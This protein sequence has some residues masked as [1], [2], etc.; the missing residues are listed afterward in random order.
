MT[1]TDTRDAAPLSLDVLDAALKALDPKGAFEG[2]SYSLTPHNTLPTEWWVFMPY[3]KWSTYP[4]APSAGPLQGAISEA[5]VEAKS[6]LRERCFIDVLHLSDQNNGTGEFFRP[7]VASI[8]DFI[9]HGPPGSPPVIRYVVGEDG[10]KKPEDSEFMRTLYDA[11]GFSGAHVYYGNFAPSLALGARGDA[12]SPKGLGEA[13][14]RLVDGALSAAHLPA[15]HRP[16]AERLLAALPDGTELAQLLKELAQVLRPTSWNHAKIFALNGSQL[17]IGGANYW[18][19]Y[20]R[21]PEEPERQ[22]YLFDL[23]V[24]IGGDAAGDAHEFANYLWKYLSH[25][26]GT[27]T[28]SSSA[29][30]LTSEISNFQSSN[31][32]PQLT[33]F[34]TSAG[35]TP[36]LT[37]SRIGNWPSPIGYPVQVVDACRDIVVN[38]IA[39]FAETSGDESLIAYACE[40]L[41]DENLRDALGELGV[42]PTAWASRFTHNYAISRAQ[43]HVRLSQ[44]KLVM[45]DLAA[46]KQPGFEA[47]LRAIN[48]LLGTSWNGYI[49][50]FDTL[51]ALGHAL[52]T[53][54]QNSSTPGTVQIVCSTRSTETGYEDPVSAAEFRQKLV[55]VMTGMYQMGYIEPSA[56]I[57]DIVATRLEYRRVTPASSSNHANHSKLVLVDDAICYVG[58]DNL[59]PNYNEE[60]GIWIDDQ[61]AIRRF[62]DEWWNGLWNFAEAID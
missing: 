54:S 57:P 59:Y 47:F 15:T 45:D 46:A 24:R 5:I 9:E 40:A 19:E 18:A 22:V 38:V 12:S 32:A 21:R 28:N 37:V 31:E 51:S 44:Q 61:Q 29:G 42:N 34:P 11:P 25:I 20:S 1:S 23:S 4:A 48:E 7:I 10:P 56:S 62:V 50:P 2:I 43:S 58:S 53:F 17:V 41:T 60:S 16:E 3:G 30:N 49:W 27:D 55:S 35:S 14:S 36:A 6:T 8:V 52:A 13:V 39:A 33:D 26:P